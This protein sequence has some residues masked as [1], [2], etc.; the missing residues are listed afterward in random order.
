MTPGRHGLAT[1][2]KTA[3]LVSARI[4]VAEDDIK[5]AELVR[6]YLEREGH[7]VTV[8][9]DGRA[10]LDQIR[11]KQPDLVVLDVMMPNVDGLDVCRILRA[12]SDI[13]IVMVTARST[14]D[15]MLLGL[16]LGADDYV[17]KPYSPREL[18]ARIRTVLRRAG[19]T[20]VAGGVPVHQVGELIID[21]GRHEVCLAGK[22]VEVTPTEFKL[23]E[24]LASV[25]GRA[26]SRQELLDAALGFDHYALERTVDVHIMNLRRKVE[27]D[28]RH[29][30]Y[31]LTVYGRGYK[32]AE[33]DATSA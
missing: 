5:Q 8:V 4:L 31:L 27:D 20:T 25:P 18:M 33:L 26:R 28:H 23:L 19:A 15:D 16:D 11:Q 22:L 21:V 32:M 2:D 6:M 24:V 10:A 17:V 7:A 13:P 30:R 12:E 3:A 9:R 14:E 1:M 29:P